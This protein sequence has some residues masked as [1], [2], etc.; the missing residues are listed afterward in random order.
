MLVRA[1]SG[2]AVSLKQ[3]AFY[4]VGAA[5]IGAGTRFLILVLLARL[6]PQAQVGQFAYV[7]FLVDVSFLLVCFGMNA[8]AGRYLAEYA[9]EPARRAS[10]FVWWCRR[11]IWVPPIA[12][13]AVLLV[14]LASGLELSPAAAAGIAFWAMAYAGQSL[15]LAAFAGLQRFD[16]VFAV[17]AL[18]AAASLSA[19]V[20]A[21]WAGLPLAG[22]Y[23]LM[24]AAC[25]ASVL[26][27]LKHFSPLWRAGQPA[28]AR[29]GFWAITSS[30]SLNMWLT[31]LLW[32]LVWSRGELPVVRHWLGDVA[33]AHY[34]VALSLMAGLMT[35]VMLG[36]A[37]FA[38]Q[39]TRLWGEDRKPEAYT[40]CRKVS[41]WQLVVAAIGAAFVVCFNE[42]LVRV[43]FGEGYA[44]SAAIL[45]VLVCGL[46]VMA[47]A[48]Q[49]HLIQ[50]KTNGRF[51][52][53]VAVLGLVVLLVVAI[54]LVPY[55]GAQ[56]AAIARVATMGLMGAASIAYL[57][58][59]ID[60]SVLPRCP[61]AATMLVPVLALVVLFDGEEITDRAIVFLICALCIGAGHVLARGRKPTGEVRP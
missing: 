11:S 31:A 12:G 29:P 55:W 16:Q 32:A 43:A 59:R 37:V 15:L 30:Y 4:A 23:A 9:A 6:F 1:G 41:E 17:T 24:G 35:A 51:S 8:A 56:G 34:S 25:I 14:L 46:P 48:M 20:L 27:A 58:M 26:L 61:I 45:A 19:V 28:G 13:G 22:L 50:I 52:R 33:L 7:L 44:D 3:H 40:L 54:T 36:S 42:E 53:N 2:V 57:L 47:L 21:A 10:F 49:N 18:G 60:A 5:M 39:V 38:A